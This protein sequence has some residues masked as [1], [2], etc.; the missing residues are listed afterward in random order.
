M[1]GPSSGSAIQFSLHECVALLSRYVKVVGSAMHY[2]YRLGAPN[3]I[4][5]EL[6]EADDTLPEDQ[7][8]EHFSRAHIEVRVVFH[9]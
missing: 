2:A 1:N 6:N 7:T 9:I 5:L 3:P 4:E 8:D